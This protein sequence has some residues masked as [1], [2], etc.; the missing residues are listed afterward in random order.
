MARQP[1]SV[2]LNDEIANA[3]RREATRTGKTETE[4]VESAIRRLVAPSVL[5][6]L[7]ERATLTGDEAMTIAN[8]EIKAHR[9]KKLAG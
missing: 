1:V 7:W 2:V 4:V 5:D 3:V 9:D 8:E 6:R